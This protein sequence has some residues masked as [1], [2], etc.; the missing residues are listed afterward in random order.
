MPS[1]LTS[2]RDIR[3]VYAARLGV[4]GRGMSLYIRS[5]ADHEPG[6]AAVVAGRQ[7]GGAVQ[8]NRAKRRLRAV[9]RVEGVPAG[10]DLVVAAKSDAVAVP[11][12]ALLQEFVRL[13][14][15]ALDRSG[16]PA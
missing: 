8:R 9:L 2:S 6:R 11:Y 15:R 5:R 13:R 16:M 1:T 3:A 14:S 7:V 4:H 10:C 12:A